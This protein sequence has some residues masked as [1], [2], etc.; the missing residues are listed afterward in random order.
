MI[1]SRKLGTGGFT[2]QEVVEG[3]GTQA[4]TREKLRD[5]KDHRKGRSWPTPLDATGRSRKVPCMSPAD[6]SG[7]LVRLKTYS[8]KE[9]T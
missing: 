1:S 8:W 2:A 7:T 5:E 3:L 6:T 9:N 4:T